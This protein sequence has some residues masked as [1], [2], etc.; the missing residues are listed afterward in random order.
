MHDVHHSSGLPEW[1]NLQLHKKEA[2]ILVIDLGMPGVR[3]LMVVERKV[4][5][6]VSRLSGEKSFSSLVLFL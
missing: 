4:G 3:W 1:S 6:K 2:M 5:G